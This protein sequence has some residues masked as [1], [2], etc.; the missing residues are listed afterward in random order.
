MDYDEPAEGGPD[1]IMRETGEV[2]LST[3]NDTS[4]DPV[5]RI[6]AEL[7]SLLA[8]VLYHADALILKTP[9]SLVSV[10]VQPLSF[11]FLIVIAT[12]G[13]LFAPALLGAIVIFFVGV[14]LADLPIEL[15]GMK[16]RSQFFELFRSLPLSRPTMAVGMAV[17]L[18]LPGLLYG[19]LLLGVVI[20]LE[21]LGGVAIATILTVCLVIWIWSVLTG[22][23]LGVWLEKVIHV[24]RATNATVVLTTTF[25]PVLYPV[26]LLPGSIQPFAL[27]V[28]TASASYLL[29]YAI[30][31]VPFSSF[32]L[33]ALLAGTALSMVLAIYVKRY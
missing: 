1:T 2:T 8:I 7:H 17:G 12:G 13:E 29:R 15:S 30:G 14:G 19:V 3:P 21:G 5:E 32:A 28:P 24:H 11:L 10:A 9:S 20:V 33:V 22:Y 4:L 25:A 18:S 23:V 31:D 6:A 27:L 26:E 16:R